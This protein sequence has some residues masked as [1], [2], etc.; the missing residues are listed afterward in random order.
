MNSFKLVK[1]IVDDTIFIKN[2]DLRNGILTGS[3]T[4]GGEEAVFNLHG[5]EIEKFL[6]GITVMANK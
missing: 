3:Y 2:F 5:E 4:K 1:G 6:N